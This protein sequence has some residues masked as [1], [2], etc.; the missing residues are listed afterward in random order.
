MGNDNNIDDIMRRLFLVILAVL[1]LA[2]LSIAQQ[3]TQIHRLESF[4]PAVY[5]S[6]DHPVTQ[7]DDCELAVVIIH[8]WNGGVVAGNRA[9]ILKDGLPG[10]YVIAPMFPTEAAFE[11]RNVEYDGR[12]VWN[13]SWNKDLRIPGSASDDWRGGGD[14]NGTGISSFDVV[15][16]I[17][18]Q[19]SDRKRFPNLKRIVLTGF[20]G[21]GQFVSRYV[22]VGKGRVRRGISLA[23][24]SMSPSTDFRYEKEVPWLW[25]LKDRPRYSAGVSD[26]RIMRNLCSRRCWKACGDRDVKESGLDMTQWGMM[27]GMNRYERFR[28]MEKYLDRYPAWKANVSFHTFEGMAHEGGRAYQDSTLLEFIAVGDTE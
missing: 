18:R 19:L 26:R 5:Y 24:V 28:N 9:E 6:A 14:A 17:F 2:P 21:G 8:G 1:A 16:E 10:A 3:E 13:G 4:E 11:K 22:A 12:A 23:Y 7:P 20:S 15:D 27:Q 25:G